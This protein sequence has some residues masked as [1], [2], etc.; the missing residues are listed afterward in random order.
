MD[1]IVVGDY[2]NSFITGTDASVFDAGWSRFTAL[3]HVYAAPV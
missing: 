3:Y 2:A 1:T